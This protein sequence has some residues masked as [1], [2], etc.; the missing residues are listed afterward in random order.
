MNLRRAAI[1]LLCLTVVVSLGF[2]LVSCSSL[3]QTVVSPPIIEGASF[4]GNQ[5]CYYCHTNYVR[6]FAASPH[7]RIHFE[8]AKMAGQS[9]CESCHGPGSLHIQVGGGSGKFIIN[10][11]KDPAVCFTCH[12]ETHAEFNLPQHHPVIEGKMNCVQCHDPH[13]MDIMKPARGLAMARLNESCAQCHR[14]QTKPH[15]FEHEAM[16]D[17]CVTCHSPHGSIN[18]KLLV[19]R[20]N[21]LCLKCHAQTPGPGV[22]SGQIFIGHEDHTDKLR[23]GGCYAS[24]CHTAVHGSDI[25]RRLFY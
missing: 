24:G 23:M 22:A 10:P 16:R 25:D 8:G 19:D 4:V 15:V 7:A 2:I 5:A 14:E 21:N 12:L 3:E 6:T 9:G 1:G 17:G 11:G 20:D 13:G 18:A